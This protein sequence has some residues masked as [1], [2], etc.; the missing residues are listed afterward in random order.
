MEGANNWR[1]LCN[2]QSSDL[3][4]GMDTALGLSRHINEIFS[5]AHLSSGIPVLQIRVINT[6][7]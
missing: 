7:L 6:V 5:V 4:L 3:P 2:R 1:A